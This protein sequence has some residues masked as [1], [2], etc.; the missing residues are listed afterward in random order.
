VAVATTAG[1]SES[2]LPKPDNGIIRDIIPKPFQ[3]DGKV[4]PGAKRY[5]NPCRT[6]PGYGGR[7]QMVAGGLQ[8]LSEHSLE[9]GNFVLKLRLTKCSVGGK[10]VV[11]FNTKTINAGAKPNNKKCQPLVTTR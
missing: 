8:M 10:Y 6:P 1:A 3:P 4:V 11:G 7:I 5:G 2:A 9:G